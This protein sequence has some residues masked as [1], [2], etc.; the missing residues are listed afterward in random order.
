MPQPDPILEEL[1][2][3][4][5]DLAKASNH[6]LQRI[7]EAARSRQRQSGRDAVRLPPKQP[8]SAKKAS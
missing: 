5:D 6:D 3:I 8:G 7:A 4:R 1:H 2:A